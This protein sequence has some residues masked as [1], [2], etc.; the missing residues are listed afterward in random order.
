MNLQ[1]KENG[2][3]SAREL[4]AATEKNLPDNVLHHYWHA[5]ARSQDLTD[6]PLP[7]KLLDHP[8]VIW[9]SQNEVVAFHDLC[10][11]RGTPLSL[12][13]LDNGHIVC[14]YHGWQY[15]A[16]G[17]CT[18]IPSLPPDR[19]IPAKARA[20]AYHA[21]EKYGLIWVCL[22]TPVADI[23]ELPT[24][25]HDPSYRWKAYSSHGQ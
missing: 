7:V 25:I 18:R 1:E 24:E 13:W 3:N 22:K 15:G 4:T 12:G 9:R 23:P 20:V 16:D 10:V 5:V 21:T 11:H 19:A 6:K 8:V 2:E 14:A 17:M